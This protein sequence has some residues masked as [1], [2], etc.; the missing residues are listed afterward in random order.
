MCC[1]GNST[2]IVLSETCEIGGGM[3][4]VNVELEANMEVNRF[5]LSVGEDITSGTL[6]IVGGAVL[7]LFM[8]WLVI[9]SNSRDRIGFFSNWVGPLQRNCVWSFLT[10]FSRLLRA[11]LNAVRTEI[12]CSLRLILKAIR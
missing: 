9:F 1:D 12:L 11:V 10:R 2:K 8:I 4:F 5:A 7:T 6:I 3:V